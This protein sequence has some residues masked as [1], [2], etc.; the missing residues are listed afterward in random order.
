[1]PVDFLSFWL[2][3]GRRLQNTRTIKG[4]FSM[5]KE[6]KAEQKRIKAVYEKEIAKV[7]YNWKTD[8]VDQHMVDY[9]VKKAAAFAQMDDGAVYVI[10]KTPI[11]TRFCFGYSDFG[12]GMTREEANE[13]EDIFKKSLAGFIKENMEQCLNSRLNWLGEDKYTSKDYRKRK[14]YDNKDANIVNIVH[15][16][17]ADQ[18]VGY[19]YEPVSDTEF[20]RILEAEEIARVEFKKKLNAYLKRYGL[21]KVE[22]WT[23][24]E[25]E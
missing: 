18:F 16:H 22:T 14:S 9:C 15:R 19:D 24:W 4:A 11:K 23:Y 12:Q 20:T 25:D 6:Q 17:F 10:D 21:S 8:R 3:N 5:T 1:M 7:W 2:Y 13:A